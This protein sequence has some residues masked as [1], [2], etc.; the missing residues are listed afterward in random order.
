[1]LNFQRAISLIKP[2]EFL[3][4]L[5]NSSNHLQSADHVS[6]AKLKHFLRY[7]ADKFKILKFSK[8]NNSKSIKRNWLKNLSSH[9]IISKKM[10]KF[11]DPSTITFCDSL[12]TSLKF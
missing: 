4:N 1:M 2:T 11:E 5:I 12:L 8:G 9:L 6:N 7:L 10:T 3:Q